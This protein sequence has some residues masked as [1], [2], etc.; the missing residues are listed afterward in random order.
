MAFLNFEIDLCE[1][2]LAQNQQKI[3]DYDV[4]D[5]E[6]LLVP[7]NAVQLPNRRPMQAKEQQP[8]EDMRAWAIPTADRK[9]VLLLVGDF[10]K[11]SQFQPPQLAIDEV[12]VTPALPEGAGVRN[13][14]RRS[15]GLD[16][17][18]VA[19]GTRITIKEFDTTSLI[20][21][22]NDLRLGERLRLLV[23]STRPEAVS[24]AIEQS[25]ILLQAVTEANGRL[26]ADGHEFRSKVDMKRRRQ[27]GIEGPPPDVPDL[28]ATSQKAINAPWKRWNDRIIAKPGSK[29]DGLPRPLRIV[30]NGHWQQAYDAFRRATKTFYPLREGEVEIDEDTDLKPR[31]KVEIPK[32]SR[33]PSILISPV[34][35][36]PC[37]S[38]FTLPELYIWADWIKGMPGYR[39][40]RNRIPSGDFED[41]EMISASG[42][43]DMSYHQDGLV[44]KV[45]IVH[46]PSHRPSRKPRRRNGRFA[47][48]TTPTRAA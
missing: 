5:P 35:C 28:L 42:W 41:K 34:S 26:A 48:S 17:E 14:S 9:G 20:L 8:R 11:L 39:W 7:S 10:A 15:Q 2:V 44:G 19:E 25:E 4:Y 3:R 16:R 45:S 38:F 23:E 1:Q 13:Q 12:R 6:P 21:C 32:V 29:R 27:A 33:R 30:M 36:P 31:K 24:L 40:G 37:V 22:T 47:S 46:A 18:R 43:V